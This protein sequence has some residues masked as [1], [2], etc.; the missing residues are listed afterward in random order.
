MS[1]GKTAKSPW[2]KIVSTEQGDRKNQITM[3]NDLSNFI[4]GDQTL[5]SIL[6]HIL[7]FSFSTKWS[8][9]FVV[10]CWQFQP[11]AKQAGASGAYPLTSPPTSYHNTVTPSPSM[12]H[13]QSPGK[14]AESLCANHVLEIHMQLFLYVHAF[15]IIWAVYSSKLAKRMHLILGK[16]SKAMSCHACFGKYIL[17]LKEKFS[18]TVIFSYVIFGTVSFLQLTTCSDQNLLIL[19]TCFFRKAFRHRSSALFSQLL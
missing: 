18:E 11:F 4:G 10:L 1:W 3:L 7:N 19:N 15:S 9:I 17:K 13:T 2:K 12:M 6:L 14:M 16:N 5:I 8:K